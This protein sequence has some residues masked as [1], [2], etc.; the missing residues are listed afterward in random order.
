MYSEDYCDLFPSARRPSSSDRSQILN[1][2]YCSRFQ[3]ERTSEI[4]WYG[5]LCAC[6]RFYSKFLGLG[7]VKATARAYSG[8]NKAGV[9]FDLTVA[10]SPEV[11][12]PGDATSHSEGTLMGTMFMLAFAYPG[13]GMT[14]YFQRLKY[15]L[16]M[17]T[18]CGDVQGALE[19]TGKLEALKGIV[20]C[21]V[22]SDCVGYC[23]ELSA[24]VT[25]GKVLSQTE[26]I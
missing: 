16:L 15:H 13:V 10:S 12:V 24:I 21:I 6:S 19:K 8:I 25:D 20:Q 7:R 17:A 9:T 2:F 26:D 3:S 4:M 11:T 5:Q 23:N 18:G 1:A 14:Q 22:A